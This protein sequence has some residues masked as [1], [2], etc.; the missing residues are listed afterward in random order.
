MTHRLL[1]VPTAHGVGVTSVCL[2]ILRAIDRLGLRLGFYKPVARHEPDRSTSLV[3]LVSSLDPPVPVT[4][5][6]AERML[7]EGREDIL[8][9]RIVAAVETVGA[10]RDVVVIEG[11]VT[12]DDAVYASGLNVA[13][14]RALDAELVFVGGVD[15]GRDPEASPSALNAP[16][17][18]R[19]VA[20]TV[21]IVAR[22]FPEKATRACVLNRVP[23]PDVAPLADA[24]QAEHLHPLGIIEERP[25]LNA[26]RMR[27][28]AAH[29][30]AELGC[31]TLLEGDQTG[32]RV[33]QVALC[34]ATVRLAC[35]RLVR[36]TLVIAPGDREDILVTAALAELEGAQLAGIVVTCGVTPSE[37]VMRLCARAFRDGPAMLLVEEDSYPTAAV[38]HRLNHGVPPDDGD[39]AEL[40]ATTIAN[41][42]DMAWLGRFAASA[43]PPRMT[44]PAFRHRLVAAARAAKRCIVLPE[45]E[46]PR[47]VEAASIAA[48]RGLAACVLLGDPD[49]VADVARQRGVSLG[50]GVRVMAPT[51]EL[52]E[53]YVAPMVALRKHKGLNPASA[54][55]QLAD[56]VVLGTMMIAQGELDG[57]VSGAI[58][59]TANTIRPALQLIRT[60]PGAALVSSVFFMCLPD[61][62]L[63]YGDCAVNPNP[64]AEQLADI[65]LQSAASAEAF[66]ITPRVAMIS[67]STGSS[68]H[69]EDVE[70]VARATAIARERR[71]GLI[72]DGPL[73]YDAAAVETVAKKKAPGSPVAGRATVFV[74]PD[75]NTGNTTYKAVQRS[76][77]CISIGPMLQGLAKPV[78]DLSRGSSVEDIVFTIAITAIQAEQAASR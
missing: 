11:V 36:G 69:G 60:A 52:R 29:L 77:D 21:D 55:D 41:G 64:D 4:A 57:L 61:Q 75:L 25:A 54:R 63:V 32:R 72:L 47:T 42:L 59:T 78:N 33:R 30:E 18:H 15:A 49:R 34:A 56:N 27:E 24:L 19:R 70:K 31:R 35:Q 14:A 73:Q 48:A 65:A 23:A 37:D 44:T 74:F 43:G 28:L 1:V 20:D 39:R 6:E 68:G 2:G 50:D 46:E 3:R 67:Y 51:A 22:A 71:P 26:P 45:G 16:L 40:I 13:L 10:D 7:G 17:D 53:P 66:G 9:E 8:L 62:V 12:G 5:A 76:A 38:V 58:N